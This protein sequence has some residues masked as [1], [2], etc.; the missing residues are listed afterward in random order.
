[1]ILVNWLIDDWFIDSLINWLIDWLVNWFIGWFIHRKLINWLIGWLIDW[2]IYWLIGKWIGLLIWLI[3]WLI[4]WPE[5]SSVGNIDNLMKLEKR[6]QAD[7]YFLAKCKVGEVDFQYCRKLSST[8][9]SLHIN[10]SIA[11]VLQK[12]TLLQCC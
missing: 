10:Y 6:C 1:M 5:L 11:N 8:N 4:D 12:F 9:F 2:L 7:A 3:Y